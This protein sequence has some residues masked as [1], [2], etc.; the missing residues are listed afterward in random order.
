MPFTSG[1]FNFTGVTCP[2]GSTLEYSVD[3]GTTWTTTTPTYPNTSEESFELCVRCTCNGSAGP[4]T[5][6]PV[7]SVD[8]NGCC[9]TL[10]APPA[11]VVTDSICE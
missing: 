9:P 8:P 10:T 5:C 3:G 4:M 6:V 11:P 7:S 2:S 1:N